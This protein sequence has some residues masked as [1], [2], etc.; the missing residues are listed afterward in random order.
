MMEVAVGDKVRVLGPTL[1]GTGVGVVE[2]VDERRGR[3]AIGRWRDS[4]FT[5]SAAFDEM[6]DA[7]EATN[8]ERRAS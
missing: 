2:E 3:A 6:Y 4:G 1:R 5:D 7:I 8:A